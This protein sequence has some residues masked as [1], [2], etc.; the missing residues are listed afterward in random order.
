[1]AFTTRGKVVTVLL[2]LVLVAGGV[3]VWLVLT[4]KIEGPISLLNPPD[5]SADVPD[6]CP[7]TGV[8]PDGD[9]PDRPALAI[10][11]ENADGARPQAGME[12][13]DVT[14]EERVEGG[15]TRFIVI[16]Q[17]QDSERIGPVRSA[18]PV[19]PDVL[20]QLGTETV[21]GYSGAADEVLKIVAR[22][23]LV[24]VNF[25]KFVEAYRR[26]PNREQPHNLYTTTEDL[27]AA[28]KDPT[29]VPKTLWQYDPAEP[30]QAARPAS[31]IHV[32]FLEAD[33]VWTWDAKRG[34]WFRA[35]D[36]GPHLMED[37]TQLLA[38]NVIV[39][40]VQT[41]CS[42]LYDVNN[43]C[44]DEVSVVGT[45]NAI[46]FRNGKAIRGTWVREFTED[47]TKFLDR[48]GREIRLDP[49]TTWV[50]LVPTDIKATFQ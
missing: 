5:S 41:F 46:V 4:K 48:R 6:N 1:M 34:L 7:L 30:E 47:V 24:D 23:G 17:C 42:G 11:V 12:R 13:A 31:S 45:G 35:Q 29:G 16:Y 15:I 50:E 26:D 19:D 40:E 43:V 10:K 21:F 39:Q 44:V 8:N 9:V 38:T 36:G 37:G 28:A 25:G 49:G 32:P 14:Y 33:V 20:L 2:T 27:Y 3:Y 22:S 18:R